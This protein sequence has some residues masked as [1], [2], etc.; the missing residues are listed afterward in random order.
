M[1][2]ARR[3]CSL[4][5][6]LA[7]AL[8]AAPQPAAAHLVGVA[9]GDFYAGAL[10][11]LLAPENA[12]ALLALGVIAALHPRARARWMLLALPIGLT[13]GVAAVF[14]AER[15]GAGAALAAAAP[16]DPIIALSL[17]LPGLIGAASLRAPLWAL[18][19]LA[20]LV[21]MAQGAVNGLA[22]VGAEMDW[23]LFAPGVVAAGTVIGTL[24]IALVVAAAAA[25]DWV[26]IAAR[27]LSSWVGAAGLVFLGVSLVAAG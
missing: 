9:F 20:A 8:A 4:T 1:T 12:A 5:A 15:L 18:T 11:L 10:H 3:R 26:R 19:G 7:L 17:A 23:S 21:G 25:A 13:I 24:A 6:G 16:V 2:C 27:V 14:A 22:A